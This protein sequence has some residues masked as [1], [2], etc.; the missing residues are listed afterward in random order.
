[1]RQSDGRGGESCQF[2][3]VYTETVRPSYKHSVDEF[4]YSIYFMTYDVHIILS[5]WWARGNAL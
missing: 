4:E 3:E 1:M 5:V 2:P